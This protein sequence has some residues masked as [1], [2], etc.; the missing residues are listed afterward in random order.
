MSAKVL[1]GVEVFKEFETPIRG[2]QGGCRFITIVG[3][4]KDVPLTSGTSTYTCLIG[5]PLKPHEF[6]GAT[7]L[8]SFAAV[9]VSSVSREITQC[10][11]ESIDA[12][13][14]ERSGRVELRLQVTAAGPSAKASLLFSVTILAAN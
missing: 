3:T 5:P 12:D 10:S 8:P 1:S 4:L 6:L 14:D 9:S 2:P 13:H 7:C 11:L